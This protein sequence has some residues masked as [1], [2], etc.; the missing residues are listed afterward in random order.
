MRTLVLLFAATGCSVIAD[1]EVIQCDVDADCE[2]FG[3]HPVCQANVCVASGL[4]PEGCFFGEPTAQSEF[5]NRCTTSRTYQFDNCARLGMCDAP[6]LA[7]AFTTA[8]MPANL[9]AIP[10]PVNN[11]PTP[12]VNCVDVAPNIIFVTGSTNLPPLIKAVQPL[13]SAGNPAYT[14]VFAPQTSCKGAAAVYDADPLKHVIKNITNN[15]AFYYNASGAQTFCLLD[16]AGNTVDVGESDVYPSSCGYAATAGVADY[17]GPIQAITFVV[18]SGSKQTVISAEAAHL[19]FATGGDSGRATPWTDPRYYFVRSSGTGTT[20]ISSR[21]I[22]LDPTKWWGIDRLSA[23]NLVASME[24]V[25]PNVAENVIGMLSSDFADKSRAN[26]TTLAFQQQGQKYGYLPD[27][28]PDAFDKANVR[29]GHYPIWGA[30]HLMAA[31]SNGVPSQA[32]SALITQFTLPKLDEKLVGA[33][34]E[35]GFVPACAMKV[36]HTTEVGPLT[37]FKPAFGCS[38]YYDKQVKGSTAC[39]VCTTNGDCGGAT[40]KCN[41]GYCEA[42]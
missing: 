29:D 2:R 16:A 21:A 37:L 18:P 17:A 40:P 13:L 8:V 30:I 22:G 33:I 15:Y 20:Q 31:T 25:D 27:S 28:S 41:Y 5:A 3:G 11:Q 34:V 42:Q 9:G 36:M 4:G 19:V 6:A 39:T 23:S 32:A 7:A 1:T 38:C 24:A 35:S 14:A 12:T 10:P 26:L